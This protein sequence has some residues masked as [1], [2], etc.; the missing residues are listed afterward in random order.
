[1]QRAT[2]GLVQRFPQN[3]LL[4]PGDLQPSRPDWRIECL[5][6]PG[7]FRFQNRTC[8]LVRVAERPP[9]RKGVLTFPVIS[10]SGECQVLEF[11]E[12][13][14]NLDLSDLRVPRYGDV[15]YLSTHSH[16]RL[17]A[18]DD[19]IHFEE[20]DNTARMFGVGQFENYGIE[21]CR[22]AQFDDTYYLTYTA[23]SPNGVAVGMRSTTDWVTF[24]QQGLILP[25][26]NKDCALFEERINGCYYALH[27]P[28]SLHIG[29]N[30]IW[31]AES[32]DLRHWG[33]HVCI[34]RSRPG[35]WDSARVGAGAAPIRTPRG[36]LA[37]Y[38]GAD[39]RN[40]YCLGALLLDLDQPWKV[41][42]RSHEPLMEPETEYERN[43]FFG[44]VIFTNGH[45]V[46]GDEITLYYGAADTV[47]CGAK[48]RISEVLNS[49]QVAGKSSRA[50]I[51]A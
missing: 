20:M 1:M 39:E 29:G 6:N 24:Q 19:G 9:Q 36:W 12:N 14:P 25:P 10:S 23:V 42:A 50:A 44:Q 8:L 7:V 28:S 30:Y 43:G 48:L 40:R 38:H 45:L 13:D 46:D 51:P 31:L 18:S 11:D 4:C 16:L 3:P 41:L 32:P 26:H 47:I 21:D 2:A 49:L 5:L 37:I 17:L 27:R 22:V 34:A 35:M 33:N 15:G